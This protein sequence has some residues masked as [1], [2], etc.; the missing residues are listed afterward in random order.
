MLVPQKKNNAPSNI[1]F[2]TILRRYQTEDDAFQSPN[3]VARYCITT[4]DGT[5]GNV[6]RIEVNTAL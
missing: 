6:N 4:V 2:F 1:E 3:R 5:G